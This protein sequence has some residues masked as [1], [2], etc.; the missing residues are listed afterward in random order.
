MLKP[1]G[2]VLDPKRVQHRPSEI[3]S[4]ILS[5]KFKLRIT[6][7]LKDRVCVKHVSD[8][9]IYRCLINV[10]YYY[11]TVLLTQFLDCSDKG[12]M[13]KRLKKRDSKLC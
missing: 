7:G 8:K 10:N 11:T 13:T 2:T 4:K 5:M 1:E 12:G 3:L 6:V 9:N